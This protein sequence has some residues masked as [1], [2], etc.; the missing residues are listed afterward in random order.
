VGVVVP[1]DGFSAVGAGVP[2][3][4]LSSVGVGACA[5]PTAEKVTTIKT[6][7][8]HV[9]ILFMIPYLRFYVVFEI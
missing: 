6:A 4:G 3:A 8:I 5:K 7:M 9:N 1:S 2:G